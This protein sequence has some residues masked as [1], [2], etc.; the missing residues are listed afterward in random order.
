M[1]LG[2]I[3]GGLLLF[4]LVLLSMIGFSLLVFLIA[5]LYILLRNLF[6]KIEDRLD[7]DARGENNGKSKLD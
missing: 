6:W 4:L 7:G 5:V 2:F 1:I 3:K